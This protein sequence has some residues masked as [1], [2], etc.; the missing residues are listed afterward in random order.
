MEHFQFQ[1]FNFRDHFIRHRNFQGELTKLDKLTDDFL[2]TIVPRGQPHLVSLR[3]VNFPDR[4][5]RHRDF[6]VLLEAPSGPGD[7]LFQQ[8]SAFF[9]EPGPADPNGVSFRSFNFRDR[10]IRHRDFHLFVEPED[11][12]NLSPDA[13]FFQTRPS[14]LIDS[15][16]ATESADQ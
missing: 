14:V 6:R 16:T 9:L 5:L 8:D 15:G 7:Q 3:S 12:P 2:F 4:F 13:T 11:S 10:L 1:S